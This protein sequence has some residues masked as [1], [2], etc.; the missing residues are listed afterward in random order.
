MEQE[1]SKNNGLIM[2]V[3]IL[4]LLVLGLGGYIVYDKVLSNK[5][6]ATNNAQSSN[7]I[8]SVILNNLY[9]IVGILPVDQYYRNSCL[10]KA[11]ST[12]DYKKNAYEIFSWY[13]YFYS[14]DSNHYNDE[15]CKSD[16]EC[17]KALSA[18]A[19]RTIT[20]KDAKSILTLYNFEENSTNFLRPLSSYDDEYSYATQIGDPPTCRYSIEHD[21]DSEYLD[22]NTI[23]ITDKQNITEYGFFEES[24]QVK[25]QKEQ[26]V[27]YDFKKNTEGNYYLNSV[28]VK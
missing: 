24:D 1:K 27:T 15:K 13:A 9:T 19:S 7:E 28:T 5:E 23:R 26:T 16:V 11:I 12:N 8:D 22:S 4:F 17:Q 3:V 18:A 25:S 21:T 20:K 6:E 10:N 2:L 14:M